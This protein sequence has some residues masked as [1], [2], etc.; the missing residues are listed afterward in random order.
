MA[1]PYTIPEEELRRLAMA[2]GITHLSTGVAV[3]RD[4]KIL[5]VRRE[6]NDFMGGEYELPGG[7]IDTGE[8]FAE[9]VAREIREETGLTV[10]N[11]IGMFPGF[12]YSTPKKPKVRQF[13][14]IVEADGEV[15]LSDEHDHFKWVTASEVE[16][17]PMSDQMRQ[18]FAGAFKVITI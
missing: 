14:F 6:A 3:I 1:Q 16:N 8:T 4:G 13:N 12:E 11:I 5:T 17:L 9:S 18:C 10:R 7:G 2:E 15:V